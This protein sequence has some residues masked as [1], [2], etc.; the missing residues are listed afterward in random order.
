MDSNSLTRGLPTH[1]T[2][3]YSKRT[4]AI[5]KYT[6]GITDL[7][8]AFGQAEG[9]ELSLI[10]DTIVIDY[11]SDV[12]SDYS[13][14]VVIDGVVKK[15]NDPLSDV[16][17]S[18]KEVKDSGIESLSYIFE[19][20]F[21]L[22]EIECALDLPMALSAK[23]T[24]GANEMNTYKTAKTLILAGSYEREDMEYKLSVFLKRGRLTQEEHDELITL[25]NARELVE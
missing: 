24:R 7:F 2:L 10:Y 1:L 13:S 20:D 14:Y 12:V 5:K 23:S 6:T 9:E 16:I 18:V 11:D 15:I 17:E 25:M 8:K 19:L 4:G 21:R 22:L 3:F